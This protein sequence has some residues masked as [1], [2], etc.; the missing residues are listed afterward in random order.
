MRGNLEELKAKLAVRGYDL[1]V[2]FWQEVENQR[3]SIQVKTEA[4]QAKKKM[5]VPKKV[6]ELKRHGEDTSELMNQ[7]QLVSEAMKA[8]E[9]ELKELQNTITT[10]ALQ[11]PN[12]PDDSVPVGSDETDNVEVRRWGVPREFDFAIKDHTDIGESLGQL[13]FELA[14]KLT[15]ARFS[16]LKGHLAKSS[17]VRWCNLCL[18]RIPKKYGYTEMYVPYMVNS[19]SLQGTGQLPKFEE[20]LFKLRGEK[21]NII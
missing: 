5:Q 6:G 3:K 19:D 12:L 13:D 15:G 4:L 20:D 1:D 8:A 7:M 18:T 21:K 11:I 2:A 16:V 10:A 9:N 17:I 14:A